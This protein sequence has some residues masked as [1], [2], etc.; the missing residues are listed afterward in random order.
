MVN[1][2]FLTSEKVLAYIKKN[3]SVTA[4]MIFFG[5]SGIVLTVAE[6]AVIK[7]RIVA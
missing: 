6:T 7:T 4:A 5:F 2:S 3:V 1:Y